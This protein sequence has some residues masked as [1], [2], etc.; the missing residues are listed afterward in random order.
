M[1]DV[2][3]KNNKREG[4]GKIM[5]SK[6]GNIKVRIV[7]IVPDEPKFAQAPAFDICVKVED[8]TGEHDWWRGEMSGNYGKG[9]FATQTQA[10]ITTKKLRQIGWTGNNYADF[11]E[12]IGKETV[13]FVEKSTDG[14]Y[15]NL[16]Y[17]GSGGGEPKGLDASTLADRVKALMGGGVASA[18]APVAAK[19]AAPRPAAPV[20][21]PA[22]NPFDEPVPADAADENFNPFG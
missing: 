5:F 2:Q 16:K 1:A 11:S 13:A 22:A 21:A 17:L 9:N 8:E 3:P 10:Q 12:L 20:A 6:T 4:K 18:P 14:K 7:E 15:N 19:P